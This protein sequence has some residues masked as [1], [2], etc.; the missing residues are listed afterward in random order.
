[1]K[2][3]SLFLVLSVVVLFAARP[4]CAQ[5]IIDWRLGNMYGA[6]LNI[7][8]YEPGVA[9]WDWDGVTGSNGFTLHI[10][11]ASYMEEY[12]SSSANWS[13]GFTYDLIGYVDN[14]PVVTLQRTVECMYHGGT[15]TA[16][17]KEQGGLDMHSIF[18]NK[19]LEYC[20]F[21]YEGVNYLP[22]VL[23]SKQYNLNGQNASVS[24]LVQGVSVNALSHSPEPGT[25]ALIGIGL[26]GLGGMARRKAVGKE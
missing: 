10:S 2:R 14:D 7:S 4:A 12:L 15:A 1:M 3:I 19:W 5:I 26:A 8:P 16:W 24:Y 23:F 11:A 18:D 20:V 17:W 9:V 22:E 21:S 6:S 25:L 13:Y